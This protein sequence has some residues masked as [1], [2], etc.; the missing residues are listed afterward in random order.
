MPDDVA[1]LVAAVRR[2]YDDGSFACGRDN[3][4]GLHLDDY[5]VSARFTLRVEY[6]GVA[7]MLVPHRDAGTS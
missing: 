4:I 5:Q 7:D 6:R 3:P 2:H 1:Q